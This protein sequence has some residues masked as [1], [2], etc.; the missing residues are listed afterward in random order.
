MSAASRP[1][2][3]IWRSTRF[4]AARPAGRQLARGDGMRSDLAVDFEADDPP[5]VLDGDDIDLAAVAGSTWPCLDPY[6][7]SPTPSSA[8]PVS[9]ELSPFAALKALKT[10]GRGM[11][12]ALASCRMAFVSACPHRSGAGISAPTPEQL[13]ISIDA[14]GGD[15]GCPWS[16][17]R[18]G[19]GPGPEGPGRAL[20][21]AWGPARHRTGPGEGP[22]RRAA[23]HHP[24]CRPRGRYGREAGPGHAPRQGTSMWNAIEAVCEGKAGAR[25][26]A[27]NTG[28]DGHVEAGSRA[29][30]RAGT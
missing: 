30:P 20:P 13:V 18:S 21:A 25:R 3:L 17:R 4:H 6:P 11:T 28:P 5:D 10:K 26:P 16:F 23:L 2:H 14:M 1:I 29:W 7:R 19:G 9:E 8:P 22:A 12:A 24:S 15:H 27:G